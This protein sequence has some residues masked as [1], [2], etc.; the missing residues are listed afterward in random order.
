M[1]DDSAFERVLDLALDQYA[2]GDPPAVILA[3]FPNE[4]TALAP[5]LEI[6]ARAQAGLAA[7]SIPP[8]DLAHGRQRFLAAGERPPLA[9]K[10]AVSPWERLA[11]AI[12]SV[13]ERVSPAISPQRLALA[14]LAAI[15]LLVGA[16]SV[17][18]TALPG[19]G[20]YP[21]KRAL[22]TARLALT[23][24][25]TAREDLD[26]VLAARRRQEAAQVLALGR[27]AALSFQG[28][29]EAV[30]PGQLAISGLTLLTPAAQ[31]FHTGD[32]VAVLARATR[33]GRLI[34][35]RLTLLRPAPTPTPTRVVPSST[36]RSTATPPAPTRP[37]LASPSAPR[38]TARPPTPEP[39]HP[40][41]TL[42][43]ANRDDEP[44][45]SP[46]DRPAG[47]TPSLAPTADSSRPVTQRPT[48]APPT[49]R[50][51]TNSPT[52]RPLDPSPTLPERPSATP[53]PGRPPRGST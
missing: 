4:H 45:A 2:A 14:S 29:V 39:S 43:P 53:T 44:T 7:T 5:L 34:A 35:T 30:A 52:T 46:I 3:R 18:A 50:P 12:G 8:P 1:T 27:E 41:T 16:S 48:D 20:L 19:D 36:P 13:W 37:A 24:D 26:A 11:A 10:A 40:T 6:A 33:D 15:V 51:P 17:S 25:P 47:V 23:F 32:E 22:E 21:L 38:P 42:P 49:D 28:T 31:S 9:A